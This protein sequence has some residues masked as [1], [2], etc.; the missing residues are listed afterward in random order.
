[1]PPI[2]RS[3]ELLNVVDGLFYIEQDVIDIASQFYNQLNSCSATFGEDA[4]TKLIPHISLI[5]LSKLT[6]LSEANSELSKELG[7]LKENLSPA[8]RRCS[9]LDKSYRDISVEC[10]ELEAQYEDD[11][12]RLS[13]QLASCREGNLLVL[14]V[15]LPKIGHLT[16]FP[17][18]LLRPYGERQPCPD[19]N[20]MGDIN[21]DLLM[22]TQDND[23]R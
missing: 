9:N 10:C 22:K 7:I 17:N 16:D 1:M 18:I 6:D 4:I 20:D 19:C 15:F 3:S 2:T 12:G 14:G 5:I 8:E 23:S 13:T 21:A 11:I